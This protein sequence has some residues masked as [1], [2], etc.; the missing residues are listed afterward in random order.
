MQGSY[1][2]QPGKVASKM[3]NSLFASKMPGGFAASNARQYLQTRWGLGRGRQDSL[4]LLAVAMQPAARVNSESEAKAFFDTVAE[5]Y[6]AAQGLNLSVATA[7]AAAGATAATAIDPEAL[8]SITGAQE[9]LSRKLLQIYAKQCGVDLQGDRLALD[10]LRDTLEKELQAELGQIQSEHGEEYINGIKPRFN[11]LKAR[12]YD[13]SWNWAL[14]DLLQLYYEISGI[15]RSK[16]DESHQLDLNSIS[17]RCSHIARAADERLLRVID[18]MAKDLQNSLL[19][20]SVFLDLSQGCQESIYNGPLFRCVPDPVGPSTTIDQEGNIHYCERKRCGSQRFADLALPTQNVSIKQHLKGVNLRREPPLHLKK[21]TAH[22]WEYDEPLTDVMHSVLDRAET[23]GETFADRC[24]LITGAGIG[25]IGAEMLGG[26]LAAGAKVVVTTSRF[27]T[28]VARK[29]QEIYV[30]NGARGSELVVVPFNQA[31][32][33]D[34]NS[35]VEFIYDH[36]GLNWDLDHV[37]PFAAISE[38]GRQIDAIDGRSELAHRIMLT[39]LLRLLGAIKSQKQARRFDTRPTQVILPLSPNHGLFGGDGLY[40]ESKLALE[41]MFNRWHS[42]DWKDYLSICGAVIGWTRGT[43]LM[44]QNDLVAE[45]VERLGVRTFSQAEMAHALA[46]LMFNAI[47]D[48][49]Q[50]EPVY[51][52]L[53]GGMGQ[54][55]ELPQVVQALRKELKETSDIQQALMKEA[56]LEADC[57]ARIEGQTT[58]VP[59][60]KVTR[61]ANFR[62]DFPST[63][64]YDKEIAPLAKDLVDMVDLERVVVVTGFSEIGPWGN[65][66][67]RWDMEAHGEFSLEGCV[68]MAWLMGL[69]KHQQG[70]SNGKTSPGWVDSKTGAQ[71]AEYEVKK[72][73]EEQI[74][75]HAGIRLI[76]PE[77]FNGYNPEKKQYLHEVII[78][79]DLEPLEVPEN[80]AQHLKMAHGEHADIIRLP[81]SDL[82]RVQLRKGAKLL[83]PKAMRFDRLVAGQIPTGWNPKIYGIPDDI[84]AQVDSVTLYTLICAA[85]ALLSSGITDPY[86]IYKY[87]HL[88]EAGNCI[89]S[90]LG[91]LNALQAFYKGRYLEQEVQKDILQESFINTIGAWVN[92]LLISSCGPNR[93]PVG[94]CAT[95]IESLELGYDTIV[96]GKAKFCFVGGVDDFGE[97]TSQEFANMKATSNAVEEMA[98]GRSPGEMSRPAASTRAGFMESQGC[99]LQILTSAKLALEMGLPI[100]GVVAFCGTA[101][102]K[103]G[104]SVPAPGKGILTNAREVPSSFPIPMLSLANRKKRL[105]FRKQQ[106]QQARAAALEEL[107]LEV[108]DI[109]AVDPSMNEIAYLRDRQV[110]IT[111]EYAKELK[112]AQYALGNDFWRNEPRIAPLRG[113]LATWGLTIDDLDVASFHGTSTVLNEKNECNVVSRQLSNL[114]RTPGNVI[115]GVFQKYLTGH[116]KGAAG[117]WMLNGALQMLESGLV[118]GNRNADNVDAALRQYDQVAFLNESLQTHGLKAVTVTSFGFGQK[119]AQAVAVHPKYLFAT[120]QKSTYD[121]YI[122]RR[123]ERQKKADSHFYQSVASNSIFRAKNSA[124]YE[125]TQEMNVLLNPAARF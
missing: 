11:R 104:R 41:T 56:S 95:S 113:S 10:N 103:A 114:G 16:Q 112:N 52:D 20:S 25:S 61:M 110:Q 120:L 101:S 9:E 49:S 99:G 33:Q 125:A 85:E 51:A 59:G 118:P 71:V 100:R 32:L 7:S 13:S 30:Q 105:N 42:E 89:G 73:Y 119:G 67:T 82:Y 96:T 75:A 116:S 18:F 37:V 78:Q 53:T 122:S 44:N 65:S 55:Q 117:A 115:L 102:D 86:E 26:L 106:I 79:E 27:S 66:R 124:P 68:E 39:N 90:G 63:L 29:Y 1:K 83:I 109:A 62:L 98:K 34:I 46:C 92:M 19:L 5:K 93:T 74:L 12:R 23:V 97:E 108:S 31:S 107:K 60:A 123:A 72:L 22:G 28:D 45:G 17:R 3:L 57:S 36:E 50:K 15:I 35:L 48:L 8:K 14:Q 77:L 6:A 38:N 69:I 58:G 43:G 80:T 54:L 87:I 40:S 21:K 4:L 88:S 91:G 64:E 24:V 111:D 70:S 84:I 121:D 94:A 76:E 47:C 81:D 2:G